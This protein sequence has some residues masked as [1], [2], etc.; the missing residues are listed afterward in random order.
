VKAPFAHWDFAIASKAELAEMAR[1][2]D[3][4]MTT[5]DDTMIT[6]TLST[7]LI[8]PDGKVV[9]FYP[10]NDWT[11]AQVLADLKQI[12]SNRA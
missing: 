8:G 5:G 2:F 7:T 9:R 12:S 10:G 3:L 11:P 4:G 1:F 6:H